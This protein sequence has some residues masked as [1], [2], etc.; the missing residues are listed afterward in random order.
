MA[1]ILYSGTRNASSWAFR[2]WL[3]LREQNIDFE[4]Q[5]VDIRRPQRWK[6][7]AK[8]GEFSPPAAVPVLV[9]DGFVIFDS[10]AIM[11]YANEIGDSSLLPKDLKL[12]ARARSMVA[13]QHST[14]GRSIC[15]G[16]SFESA[17]Y[18]EKKQLSHNEIAS[19]E[20]MYL[21]WENELLNHGGPY[22]VGSYSL[23]DIALVPSILR[24]KTHHPVS[25]AYPLTAVWMDR[26]LKRPHVEE[27]LSQAADLPPIY[28]E[29]YLKG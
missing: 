23:A 29:G 11:E 20:K 25:A 17:F 21:L 3:A 4:E 1:R 15:S 22:L 16:L 10:S 5:I 24:L 19:A 9:D 27:W 12:R 26:I 2:A 13:W 6:N 18:P 8:I 28:H 7:L 14:M